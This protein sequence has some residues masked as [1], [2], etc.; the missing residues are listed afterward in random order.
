MLQCHWTTEPDKWQAEHVIAVFSSS[1]FASG[2][3]ENCQQN[4]TSRKLAGRPN[5]SLVT[6]AS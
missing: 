1:A 6:A 3:N 4:K 5:L 2:G